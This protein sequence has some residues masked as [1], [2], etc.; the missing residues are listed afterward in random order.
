MDKKELV[1]K[2]LNVYYGIDGELGK[3][4]DLFGDEREF[5]SKQLEDLQNLV[6]EVSG[7]ADRIATYRREL[8][9][10]GANEVAW[11]CLEDPGDMI[12]A[13]VVLVSKG[14]GTDELVERDATVEQ[15]ADWLIDFGT[16][17][18]W[19]KPKQKNVDQIKAE[20]V[21]SSQAHQYPIMEQ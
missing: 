6:E 9:E 3:V 15:V 14:D 4:R 5:M 20:I 21:S 12:F 8:V 19:Y 16:G 2:L 17:M 7:V 13:Q 10:M 18:E 11:G 1:V